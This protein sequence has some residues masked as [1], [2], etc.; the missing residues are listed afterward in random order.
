MAER[1]ALV[2]AIPVPGPKRQRRLL[3]GD[4]PNPVDVPTGCA[5]H[6]RC[7]FAGEIC[8]AE[9]PALRVQ[10]DGRWVACHR[11]DEPALQVAA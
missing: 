7:P 4:P 6:T 10:A 5:F 11:V 8:R 2:S 3:Q 9:T 1:R